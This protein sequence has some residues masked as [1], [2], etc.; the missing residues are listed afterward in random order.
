MF[1]SK[2][3]LSVAA[4]ALAI[5]ALP[6]QGSTFVA[7]SPGELL[8]QADTVVVGEVIQK[9]SFWNEDMSLI[10]TEATIHVHDALVGDAPA[11]LNVRTP[12]GAVGQFRI[13][14]HGFPTFEKG[15]RVLVFLNRDLG[16]NLE[17]TGYQQGLYRVITRSDGVDVAVPSLEG[18]RLL[19]KDGTA[20]PAPRAMELSSFSQM[21][22][23]E[24]AA[25]RAM[26]K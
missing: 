26:T 2:V 18:V 22:R 11:V 4:L 14:A 19:T 17:V 12:G 7:Q 16:G 24:T 1:R 21:L 20:A 15:Q 6:A 25:S 9:Q 5:A 3:L 8:A 10:V 13:D 23:A